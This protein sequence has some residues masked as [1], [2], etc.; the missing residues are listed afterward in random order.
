MNKFR[1][2]LKRKENIL[3]SIYFSKILTVRNVSW[4]LRS[5]IKVSL[6]PV[7]DKIG[8]KRQIRNS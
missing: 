3:I 8:L 1:E 7:R 6:T 2:C 4:Y 5:V